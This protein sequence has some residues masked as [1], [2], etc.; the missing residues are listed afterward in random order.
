MQAVKEVPL[1]VADAAEQ[2]E[3]AKMFIG[4][5]TLTL[6]SDC[7]ERAKSVLDALIY[8]QQRKF[9]GAGEGI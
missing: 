6:A 2:I 3:F 7:L 5:G 9:R 1:S 8:Q 4:H